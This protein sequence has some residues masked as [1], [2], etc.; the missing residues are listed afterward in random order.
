MLF[1]LAR[2]GVANSATGLGPEALDG[3][4]RRSTI[5]SYPDLFVKAMA[6]HGLQY[7]DILP[8]SSP[9]SDNLDWNQLSQEEDYD[10]PELHERSLIKGLMIRPSVN[11]NDNN[12]NNI[13]HD[14]WVDRYS[15][16]GIVLHLP[17]PD[18]LVNNS[19]TTG[20]TI[21]HRTA[22]PGFKISYA[23]RSRSY[24]TTAH[25]K[26]MASAIAEYWRRLAVDDGISEFMGF[27]KT[28]STANFYFRI[29][30]ESRS[31][32]RNYEDTDYCVPM[33]KY[34]RAH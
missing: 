10:E 2:W 27:E 34:L 13:P 25:Q 16:G 24:L 32:G 5:G 8:D 19:S 18:Q 29:I 7:A 33:E 21:T 15:N 12:S 3:V 11:D 1:A 22:A 17:A 9:D 6:D 20:T 30:P 14:I 31:F 28:G 26:Q 23:T 4:Q